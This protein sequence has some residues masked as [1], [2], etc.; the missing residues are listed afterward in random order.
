MVSLSGPKILVVD[1]SDV[2]LTVT[3]SVLEA[4]GYRVITHSGP[5]GCVAVILHEKPDL[6]LIDVNMPKLGGETI[7][8]LFGKAQPNSETIVL[9][10][11]TLSAERLRDK[12]SS[13]GAHGFIRK[14]DDSFEFVRQV[15]RWLKPR[16]GVGYG[17]T[18]SG[19][20]AA[21]HSGQRSKERPA[22][23]PDAEP[24]A[25]SALR[26][27]SR[28][29]PRASGTSR[30]LPIVL[31]VDG[32]MEEL[33]NY[34]RELQ[35]EPYVPDFALSPNQA[36][37]HVLSATPPDLLV[38]GLTRRGEAMDL[39]ARVTAEDPSYRT[40]FLLVVR[41]DAEGYAPALLAGYEGSVLQAPWH[42]QQL[43]ELLRRL[44]PAES[45]ATRRSL[46]G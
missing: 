39:Y 31:F 44:L 36:L 29:A 27:G 26:R 2:V 32:D 15:N 40:R 45:G 46:E 18:F 41:A 9:L 22:A 28:P 1:D 37:R 7:V 33:S 30:L 13:S 38:A 14:T 17:R 19:E 3:R 35:N 24:L 8:K 43:R 6:V 25:P 16:D 4:A 23:A 5:S 12:A 42:G 34:R 10:F 11:S 20:F 21:P